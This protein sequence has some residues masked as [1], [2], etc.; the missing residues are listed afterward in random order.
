VNKRLQVF[1]CQH[2]VCY[3]MGHWKSTAWA[4]RWT[5]SGLDFSQKKR[6]GWILGISEGVQERKAAQGKKKM[7]STIQQKLFVLSP[8]MFFFLLKTASALSL[9]CI[10]RSDSCNLATGI[11]LSQH[12]IQALTFCSLLA[13]FG[14]ECCYGLTY[15]MC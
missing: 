9:S 11:Q 8:S 4:G 5:K 1:L 3:I 13:L 14:V 6:V 15:W 12:T 7:E 10:P 2:T